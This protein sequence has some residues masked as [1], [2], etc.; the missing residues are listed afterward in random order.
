MNQKN[1]IIFCEKYNVGYKE[2]LDE[3]DL[4]L[5]KILSIITKKEAPNIDS[6]C[7]NFYY[8]VHCALF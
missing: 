2:L 4:T 3:N 7:E 1:L 5:E 6:E 8:Y